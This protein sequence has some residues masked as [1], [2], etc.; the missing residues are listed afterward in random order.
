MAMSSYMKES[1]LY[2]P[3]KEFLESQ[4]FSVKGEVESCD[5][6]AV[7]GDEIPVVVE[8]KLR[9][10]LEVI[11]QAIERLS[12]TSKV[13]IGVPLLG[14]GL[15][16]R[17]RSIMKLV[18]MLG[19]GL[20]TVDLRQHSRKVSILLDPAEYRPRISKPRKERLLGEF[21]RRVGDPNLGGSDRRRGI[22]TQYRQRALAIGHHLQ[23]QGPCKAAHVAKA[24]EEP[25]ARQI[26]YHNVYGWFE[27][28]GVGIYAISPKGKQEI[29][30]WD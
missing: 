6:V 12:L 18:R 15:E 20:L 11:L 3:I 17:R 1:D 25:K 23:S 26:L 19:L 9:L 30:G 21:V 2:P 22:M 10:N 27:R 14:S 4:G 13:Y 29:P 24:L 5:V 16:R 8:L 28:I 7:R